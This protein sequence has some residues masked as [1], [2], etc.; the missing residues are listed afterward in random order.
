MKKYRTSLWGQLI[1][2]VDVDRETTSSVWIRGRRTS[3]RTED[4]S[5]F[6]TFAEAK[7]Y[8][9]GIAEREVNSARQNLERAEGNYNNVKELKNENSRLVKSNGALQCFALHYAGEK[10]QN[11]DAN[12]QRGCC[13]AGRKRTNV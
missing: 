12:I 1:K 9:L 4:Y 11:P 8:L 13:H 2:V 7:Q 5:Y 10:V 6:D 3:K